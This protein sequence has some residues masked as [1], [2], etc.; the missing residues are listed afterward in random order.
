MLKGGADGGRR[1]AGSPAL[2]TTQGSPAGGTP[3]GRPRGAGQGGPGPGDGPLSPR[4][5][6]PASSRRSGAAGCR[7]ASGRLAATFVLPFRRL[8][9]FL[10]TAKAARSPARSPGSKGRSGA[11]GRSAPPSAPRRAAPPPPPPPT[12]LSGIP[13]AGPRAPRPRSPLAEGRARPSVGRAVGAAGRG[14]PVGRARRAGASREGGRGGSH[15]GA[16]LRRRLLDAFLRHPVRGSAG[17]LA[18]VGD[19]RGERALGGG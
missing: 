9:A 4:L 16:Q 3:R 14:R 8:S 15:L 2:P 6:P 1:T 17:P 13:R 18:N 10:S 19:P 5:P 11:A 12:S 7:R